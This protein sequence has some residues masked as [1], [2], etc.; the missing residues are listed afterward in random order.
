MKKTFVVTMTCLTLAGMLTACSSAPA[1]EDTG[2][3]VSKYV[4]EGTNSIASESNM[5]MEE[6]MEK[7]MNTINAEPVDSAEI[8]GME[9]LEASF[10][11]GDAYAFL[12]VNGVDLCIH[13]MEIEKD[14]ESSKIYGKSAE[15]ISL[16]TSNHPMIYG[17]VESTVDGTYLGTDGTFLYSLTD[18]SATKLAVEKN[19]DLFVMESTFSE[20]D[21]ESGEVNY[22]H[23]ED[24]YANRTKLDDDSKYQ[25]MR[26]MQKSLEPIE[27]E[28]KGDGDFAYRP[29]FLPEEAEPINPLIPLESENN[30]EIAEE[31]TDTAEQ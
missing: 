7:H 11:D 14:K 3:N 12:N 6:H 22:Y 30:A 13:A 15:I 20:E 28:L 19:N 18:S 25:E 16:N 17:Y 9:E 31:N 4:D 2:S 1:A 10:V 27:F 5:D 26:E 29:I 8:T 24:G 21:P 23:Y